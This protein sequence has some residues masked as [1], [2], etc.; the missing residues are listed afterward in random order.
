MLQNIMVC[1]MG[2]F[3]FCTEFTHTVTSTTLSKQ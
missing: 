3:Y 2:C 1:G